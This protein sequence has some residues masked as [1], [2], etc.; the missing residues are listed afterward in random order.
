M[1]LDPQDSATLI[2]AYK[3]RIADLEAQVQ[4]L[5]RRNAKI[6]RAQEYRKNQIV[7]L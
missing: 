1:N 7:F 6:K 5:Q 3:Q 2:K 4:S